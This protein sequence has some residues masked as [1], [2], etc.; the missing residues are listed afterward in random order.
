MRTVFSDDGLLHIVSWQFNQLLNGSF[1]KQRGDHRDKQQ[2]YKQGNTGNISVKEIQAK[3]P[4]KLTVKP[5]NHLCYKNLQFFW[6][7]RKGTIVTRFS[8]LMPQ[9]KELDRRANIGNANHPLQTKP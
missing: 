3:L 7:R 4:K 1:L 9:A 2:V 6:R 8:S 5:P